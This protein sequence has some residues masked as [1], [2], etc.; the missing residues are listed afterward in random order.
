MSAT[1]FRVGDL[2]V[3]K[4]NGT[5]GGVHTVTKVLS[6]TG[7][8]GLDGGD[9][10]KHMASYRKWEECDFVSPAIM[11]VATTKPKQERAVA[12]RQNSQKKV[13]FPHQIVADAY[14]VLT[15]I[16]NL[17]E[18]LGALAPRATDEKNFL[19]FRATCG[20]SGSIVLTIY[21]ESFDGPSKKTPWAELRCRP[22]NTGTIKSM[23][24]PDE[25][26]SMHDDD[27][28]KRTN[29]TLKVF[30]K[31]A[32]DLSDLCRKIKSGQITPEV[33]KVA[34]LYIMYNWRMVG[35]DHN[36]V[37]HNRDVNFF[38]VKFERPQV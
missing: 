4:K 13:S 11:K 31:E 17:Y 23:C 28:H 32:T 30:L 15:F 33:F 27:L 9:A 6:A 37:N 38:H 1:L 19:S 16:D 22:Y 8:M 24:A 35:W 36:M 5:S 34:W 14:D 18:Q 3:K 20:G 29:R 10:R 12:G 26:S 2:V 7:R 25:K 21:A